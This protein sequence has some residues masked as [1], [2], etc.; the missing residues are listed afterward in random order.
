MTLRSFAMLALALGVAGCTTEKRPAVPPSVVPQPSPRPVGTAASAADFVATNGSID[1]FVI[2]SSELALQRASSPRVR[3]F[4][5]RM[6]EAH[7]GTSGQLS[8]AG[9]RLNL[10]PSAILRPAH[11][12]M[13]DAL[14][15]S[16]SFDSDYVRDQRLVHQDAITL[17]SAF[18]TSGN[19]PTLR[20]VAAS[21]LQVEQR[22][23]RLLAYL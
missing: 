23:L 14:A 19:S 4:A 15:N 8:L 22:H 9:R 5:A 16:T 7:K 11:Q 12:A 13:L 17:D 21:A 20:P 1:L 3:D 2:R 6:I 10:L 18:A